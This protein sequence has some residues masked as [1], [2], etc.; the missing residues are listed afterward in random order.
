[1]R[2]FRPTILVSLFLLSLA[3]NAFAF[4]GKVVSVTDGD[5]IKVLQDGKEVKVRLYGVD[6]PEKKQDFGQVA[7]DYTAKLI[8]GKN[9]EVEAVDEDRYG[10]TVG[11]VKEG[12]QCINEELVRAG[13]AWVYPQYCKRV[14]CGK[15]K[16]LEEQAREK[17]LGLWK[18][19]N[20][21]AP[22]EWR[23]KK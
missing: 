8:A 13:Y 9:V 11:I 3:G 5:T 16:G 1:M 15:W 12:G 22:W 19:K 4:Q 2:F 6:T 7:Q 23:K 17:R 14:E 18:D 10:R 21:M 20:P